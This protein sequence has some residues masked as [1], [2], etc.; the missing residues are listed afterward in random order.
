MVQRVP[1]GDVRGA[2]RRHLVE[3][4]VK[5]ESYAWR[6]APIRLGFEQWARQNPPS[7]DLL[8][9]HSQPERRLGSELNRVN[10]PKPRT[11][12]NKNHAQHPKRVCY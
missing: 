9:S 4:R 5:E 8:E 10:T 6:L 12:R 11:Y 7:N 1:S 2:P 3:Q